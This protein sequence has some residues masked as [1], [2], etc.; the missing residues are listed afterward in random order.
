V[1]KSKRVYTCTDKSCSPDITNGQAIY[2]CNKCKDSTEHE[3]KRTKLKDHFL[4]KED[5]DEENT[6]KRF[7][8]EAL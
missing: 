8:D 7:L 2:W 1:D 3:H 6:G 5:G 4:A